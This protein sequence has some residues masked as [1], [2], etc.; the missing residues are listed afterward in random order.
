M[1]A[2]RGRVKESVL[3]VLILLMGAMVGCSRTA[4]ARFYILS[5]MTRAEIKAPARHEAPCLTL[6]IGPVEMP[7]Y[8]DRPQIVTQVSENQLQLGDFDQWA[9]PL[10]KTVMRTLADNL[11]SLLCVEEFVFYPG[12]WS[13]TDYQVAVTVTR[14]HGLTGG[15]V[16]LSAQ[17]QVKEGG[18]GRVVARNRTS[19]RK[20]VEGDGYPALVAAHSSAL[21]SLSRE[22]AEAITRASNR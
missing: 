19:I 7:E 11:A 17:W 1:M 3:F 14:F 12:E 6:G 22:I 10:G 21:A 18:S 9:E 16:S 5:D 20:A 4:P 13:G 15:V 8:L 2:M